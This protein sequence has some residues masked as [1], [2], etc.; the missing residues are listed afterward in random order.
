MECQHGLAAIKGFVHPS[1]RL[2]VKHVDCD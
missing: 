2:F 1:V